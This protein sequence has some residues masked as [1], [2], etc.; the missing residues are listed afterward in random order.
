MRSRNA[1]AW[2][3]VKMRHAGQLDAL[4]AAG[5]GVDD[6]LS[7]LAALAQP[8]PG[9]GGAEAGVA[10]EQLGFEPVD[11]SRRFADIGL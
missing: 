7:V 9:A 1:P 5:L 11:R 2:S 4:L 3:N 8:E 6:G 10:A